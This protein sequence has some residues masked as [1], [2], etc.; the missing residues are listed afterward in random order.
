MMLTKLKDF[1]LI[2]LKNKY[3]I[4]EMTKRDLSKKYAGQIF[5]KVWFFLHPIFM[6]SVYILIFSAILPMKTGGSVSRG[7]HTI[8]ILC[9]LTAWL[10]MQEAIVRSVTVINSNSAII[11]QVVFPIE[12]LPIKVVLNSMV[13]MLIYIVV[14]LMYMLLKGEWPSYMF[15][16]LPL[17]IYIQLILVIGISFILSSIGVY[18]RDLKDIIQMFSFI[19]VFVLPVI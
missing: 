18:I 10:V 15:F 19:G 4:L 12:L 14:L 8:Y 9:G 5:G 3:V 17:I 6:L 16:L 11:K 2:L 7:D 1:F 13:S